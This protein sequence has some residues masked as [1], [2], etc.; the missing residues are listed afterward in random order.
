MRTGSVDRQDGDL[1]AYEQAKSLGI[2]VECIAWKGPTGQ[3]D[4]NGH[5]VGFCPGFYFSKTTGLEAYVLPV[6]LVK[7]FNIPQ[8]LGGYWGKTPADLS[9]TQ[10]VRTSSLSDSGPVENTE[11]I[12]RRKLRMIRENLVRVR[13]AGLP[14]GMVTL[15]KPEEYHVVVIGP[16]PDQARIGFLIPVF[17]P[18]GKAFLKPDGIAPAKYE[19]AV[20]RAAGVTPAATPTPVTPG[21][22]TGAP[23][24]G[25]LLDRASEAAYASAA[26]TAS[27]IAQSAAIGGEAANSALGIPKPGEKADTTPIQAP[28]IRIVQPRRVVRR[29]PSDCR[30]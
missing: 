3:V 11:S 19:R 26:S 9:G 1:N 13:I 28:A 6:A 24:G 7:E 18:E 22:S 17:D 16:Y 12:R 5:P 27:L 14:P 2:A 10:T 30:T 25:S 29:P 8:R 15:P 21:A 4:E 20:S 23:G